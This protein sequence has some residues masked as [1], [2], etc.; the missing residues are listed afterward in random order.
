[1]FTT[2]F[3]PLYALRLSTHVSSILFQRST[4]SNRVQIPTFN[5]FVDKNAV[6]APLFHE[7]TAHC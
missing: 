7:Q 5:G 3:Q 4:A 1:M 6:L 2:T